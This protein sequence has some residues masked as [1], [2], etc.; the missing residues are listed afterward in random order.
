MST[1]FFYNDAVFVVLILQPEFPQGSQISESY[2]DMHI[3]NI[4]V[5]NIYPRLPEGTKLRDAIHEFPDWL[6]SLGVR[7]SSCSYDSVSTTGKTN[8]ERGNT[9]RKTAVKRVEERKKE[10]EKTGMG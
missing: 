10:E 9:D 7:N 6:D 5:H 2:E 8:I 3:R 4:L 1:L